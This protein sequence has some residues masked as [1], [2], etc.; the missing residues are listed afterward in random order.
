M[1]LMEL[2]LEVFLKLKNETDFQVQKSQKIPNK[3]NPKTLTPGH[4]TCKMVRVKV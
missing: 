3:M 4:I 2:M 1:Y